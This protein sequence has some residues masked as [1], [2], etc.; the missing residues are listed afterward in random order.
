MSAPALTSFTLSLALTALMGAASADQQTWE[1]TEGPYGFL[2]GEW[3]IDISETGIIMGQAH[4]ISDKGPLSYMIRGVIIE[5]AVIVDDFARGDRPQDCTYVGTKQGREIEG[6]GKCM[7]NISPWYAA[8]KDPSNESSRSE[9]VRLWTL[10]TGHGRCLDII[11][12]SA[13]DKLMMAN[14]GRYTGQLWTLEST[15]T[16]G[17]MQLKTEFT[18]AEK[19]LDVINDDA[20]DKL[21]LAPCRDFTGQLWSLRETDEE[22]F[23]RLSNEFTG[24]DRCLD[25]I[26]DEQ[27]DKLILA[28]CG[29]YTGQFWRVD[30][31]R[32]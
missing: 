15:E 9:K 20:D 23:V 32:E 12:D 8:V 2:K 28:D 30:P 19:C 29:N 31:D 1:V 4:M 6:I 16:Q 11:N 21:V 26:N 13:D 3:N 25:I 7:D 14:C 27:D 24:P 5:D 18:G 10:F 22:G 17:L